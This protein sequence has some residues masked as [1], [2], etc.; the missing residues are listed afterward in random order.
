VVR[1][2]AEAV[3]PDCQVALLVAEGVTTVRFDW[4]GRD[5]RSVISSLLYSRIIARYIYT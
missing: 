5:W 1:G 2:G 4:V 3:A